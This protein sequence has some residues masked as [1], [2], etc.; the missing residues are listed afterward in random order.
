MGLKDNIYSWYIKNLLLPGIEKIDTPGFIVTQFTE[1]GKVTYL[2]ELLL[3]EEIF[4]NLENSLVSK[5]GDDARHILY[6]IGKKFG[7]T[8]ASVS[9]FPQFSNADTRALDSFV[10]QLIRYVETLFANKI[11][12][13]I[14]TNKRTIQLNMSGYI[15]C[16][17]NGM[18][19]LWAEGGMAGIWSWL[20]ASKEIEGVKLLVDNNSGNESIVL[21]GPYQELL[22]MGLHPYT[23]LDLM[24]LHFSMQYRTI[25]GI[26]AS[27]HSKVSLR[28]LIDSGFFRYS[29]GKIT[30]NDERYFSSEVHIV[31]ILEKE[32]AKLAAG[33][34]ILSKVAFDYGKQV[35][36]ANIQHGEAPEKFIADY[37]SAS[38]WGD[39]LI[40]KKQS[41]YLI[42]VTSF[43]WTTYAMES[44]FVL[45]RGLVSGLLSG[46]L[47]SDINLE[48]SNSGIN[49]GVF[50]ISLTEA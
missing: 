12:H 28:S 31:Y 13:K 4:V 47:T 37:L 14:D 2:R 33:L 20:L 8:Y 44:K 15:I 29:Q 38:G 40:S 30:F 43:P 7:Y 34:D 10:Y 48:L 18:G 21:C 42:S 6:S 9:D 45:F 5:Y 35:S 26:I 32:L 17:K 27:K 24:A 16:E 19:Y 3:P 41:K 39:I 23:E 46:F 49:S 1:K 25:N 22:D 36:K 50:S 11:E